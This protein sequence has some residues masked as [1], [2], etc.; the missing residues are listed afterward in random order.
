MKRCDAWA[1]W[2]A[3]AVCPAIE[4]ICAG[5]DDTT[6]ATLTLPPWLPRKFGDNQLRMCG[7]S[8][9][10]V[11]HPDRLKM[12][13]LVLEDGRSGQER[14]LDSYCDFRP[15]FCFIDSRKR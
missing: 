4:P 13:H 8:V 7:T 6:A 9:L 3:T 10:R 15:F 5:D 11:T 1:R 14:Q 12:T 2:A